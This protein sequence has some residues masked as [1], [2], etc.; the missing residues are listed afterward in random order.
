MATPRRP[1]PDTSVAPCRYCRGS[2]STRQIVPL[3]SG[4]FSRIPGQ[5]ELCLPCGGT[6]TD[7]AADINE[8]ESEQF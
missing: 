2:G 3:R 8:L 4:K 7:P 5:Q 1:V 6:G